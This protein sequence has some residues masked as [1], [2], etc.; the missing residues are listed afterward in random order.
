MFYDLLQ[1]GELANGF[2]GSHSS[3]CVGA[4]AADFCVQR[5]N[6]WDF[7]EAV[8][9]RIPKS[10]RQLRIITAQPNECS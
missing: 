8:R 3:E 7:V 9:G 6:A 1:A 5:T 2:R 4:G 10:R